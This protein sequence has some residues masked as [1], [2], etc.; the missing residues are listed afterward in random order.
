MNST[1]LKGLAVI[2][3]ATGTTLGTVEHAFLDPAAMRVVGFSIAGG[4]RGT[5]GDAGPTVA[6]AAVHALG[7][8]A[9]TLDDATAARAAWVDAAAG[10]FGA[11]VP[12]DE[13]AK[14]RVVTEGGTDV[15]EVASLEFDERTFEITRVEVSPGFFKGNKHLPVDQVVRI[16]PD[17][18]VVAD[19]VVAAATAPAEAIASA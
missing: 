16:G 18:V 1:R 6:A 8:D 11:F 19:G 15:G 3:L 2:D 13:V 14:R 4:R 5:A 12:L 7:P 9:L 17:L 10:S